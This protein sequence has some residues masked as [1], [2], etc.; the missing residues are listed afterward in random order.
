MNTRP[1][2]CRLILCILDA[3]CVEGRSEGRVW[4]GPAEKRERVR[5]A[6]GSSPAL[7]P[8]GEPNPCPP[9]ASPGAGLPGEPGG[10]RKVPPV[11]FL[12]A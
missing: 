11:C 5:R 3:E 4:G 8:A 9:A 10:G 2:Y 1:L 7:A 12:G 6:R